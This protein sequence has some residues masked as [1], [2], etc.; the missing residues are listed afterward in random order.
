[1]KLTLG[2]PALPERSRRE[3]ISSCLLLQATHIALRKCSGAVC[4]IAKKVTLISIQKLW[5]T[6]RFYFQIN[7][8]TQDFNGAIRRREVDAVSSQAKFMIS[9][10]LLSLGSSLTVWPV[11]PSSNT[12][13]YWP[14]FSWLS[15]LLKLLQH[16]KRRKTFRNIYPLNWKTKQRLERL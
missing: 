4:I 8:A 12:R 3:N 11:V 9:S 15:L 14:H 7:L 1:M 2:W 13:D 16:K 6:K 5:Q 10:I